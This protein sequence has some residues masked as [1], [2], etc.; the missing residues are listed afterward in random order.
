MMNHNVVTLAIRYASRSRRMPLAERL[1]ELAMEKANQAQEDQ[2]QQEQEEEEE[3]TYS[4][5]RSG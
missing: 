3:T 5:R 4:R 1:S 2:Q